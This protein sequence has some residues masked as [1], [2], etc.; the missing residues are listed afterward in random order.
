MSDK[1]I[2]HCL[3]FDSMY[4]KKNTAFLEKALS[5]QFL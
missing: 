3:S 4:D 5:V 1:S 2:P